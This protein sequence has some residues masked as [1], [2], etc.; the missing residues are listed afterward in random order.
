MSRAKTQSGETDGRTGG[1][2]A[3]LLGGGSFLSMT[4][5]ISQL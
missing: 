4:R 2:Q 3:D 1:R 5:D